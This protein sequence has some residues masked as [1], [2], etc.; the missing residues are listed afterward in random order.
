MWLPS[1]ARTPTACLCT[2]AVG[3]FFYI[4]EIFFP[5]I[6]N[7]IINNVILIFAKVLY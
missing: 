3:N 2:Y 1:Q 5:E 7:F 4:K 6:Y